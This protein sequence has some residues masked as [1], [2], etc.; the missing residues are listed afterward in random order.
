MKFLCDY[1]FA[2]YTLNLMTFYVT[3]AKNILEIYSSFFV[4]S[5]TEAE[6]NVTCRHLGFRNGNFTYHSFSYNLTDYLLFE[7]PKCVGQENS[8]TECSGWSYIKIGPH[9]CGED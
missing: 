7:R 9:V 5:F 6:A 2:L 1:L 4:F 3:F 8:L